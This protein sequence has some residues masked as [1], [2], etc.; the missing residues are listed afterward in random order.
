[1]S[2]RV[3]KAIGGAG[4]VLFLCVYAWAVSTLGDHIPKDWRVQLFYYLL[5][6]VAWGLPVIPLIGWMNRGR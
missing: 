4:I 2:A 6:G 5:C 3:R 1:M